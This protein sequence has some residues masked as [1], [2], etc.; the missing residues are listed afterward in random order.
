VG[1]LQQNEDGVVVYDAARCI[2][3]R[4]CMYACPF[5][6]PN[7]EWEQSLALIVK[8]DLCVNRVAGGEQP[9]CA[10][11]CPTDAIK[12]G[13]RGA[14][15]EL[16]YQRLHA[17]PDKYVQHVYGEHEHGGTSTFY[18]SPV[19]FEEL[20]LPAAEGEE[21]PAH[22]N[23]LVTHGTPVVAAGVALAMA[24]AYLT[25]ERQRKDNAAAEAEDVHETE[26][27]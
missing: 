6:V 1:A 26:E 21:S 16:A 15:L 25:I 17:E 14:M 20:G 10:A 3:C 9:A 13:E 7:F 5:G 8:C 22:L 11:T 4:Y 18:I 23:R 12:F 2:G 24:G 19:P 27:N